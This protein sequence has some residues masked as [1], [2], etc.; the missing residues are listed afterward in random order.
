MQ[1]QEILIS[2]TQI[3]PQDAAQELNGIFQKLKAKTEREHYVDKG[4]NLSTLTVQLG[5]VKIQSTID[6]RNQTESF[7][8]F[9]VA[10]WAS[11]E[12]PEW[13]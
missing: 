9:A 13:S 5:E 1:D 7:Y 8:A 11:L 6:P 10:T 3:C 12:V 2:S 4:H